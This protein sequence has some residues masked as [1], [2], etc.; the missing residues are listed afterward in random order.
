MTKLIGICGSN[1]S[2]STNKKLLEYMQSQFF[3]KVD[4]EI[5]EID[6]LPL[7]DE[8]VGKETPKEVLQIAEKIT[9]ADGVIIAAPE[10]DHTPTAALL[11]LLSWMSYKIHPLDH[12]PVLLLGVSY[13]R[14]GASRAQ[15]V[16]RQILNSPEINANVYSRAYLLGY[17]KKAFDDW[18]DLKGRDKI[19]ELENLFDEFLVFTESIKHLDKSN[20]INI[21][22]FDNFNWNDLG[23][24]Q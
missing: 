16:L 7:M 4:I 9:E 24:D 21:H 3:Y 12:K 5:L 14:L 8:L 18:G 23:G 10:Y 20:L 13:G 6:K 22:D 2:Q 1:Y 11:N 19:L 17:S 15:T